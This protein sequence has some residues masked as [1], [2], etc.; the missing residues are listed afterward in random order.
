MIPLRPLLDWL[1]LNGF[2]VIEVKIRSADAQIATR[3]LAR[4]IDINFAVDMLHAADTNAHLLLI[5]GRGELVPLVKGI[6]AKGTR[7]TVIANLKGEAGCSDS[8][9]R[10]ADSFIDLAE[11]MP[12]LEKI[13]SPSNTIRSET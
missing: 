7:A 12:K 3:F 5:S 4:L 13:R 8:L 11:L 10:A 1:S 6:M 2:H 9:R